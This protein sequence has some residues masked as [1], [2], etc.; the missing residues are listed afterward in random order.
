MD[1]VQWNRKHKTVLQKE[2]RTTA[3]LRTT[4]HH[5]RHAESH[6]EAPLL[7]HHIHVYHCHSTLTGTASYWSQH[8]DSFCSTN[9]YITNLRVH[10]P[11]PTADFIPGH[12]YTSVLLNFTNLFSCT[13]F[14]LTIMYII[15]WTRSRHQKEVTLYIVQLSALFIRCTTRWCPVRGRN[16]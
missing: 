13:Y 10:S 15:R 14:N 16:M 4:S 7:Q 8:G 3:T 9:W 1:W 12:Y 11:L 5:S 6:L 2:P